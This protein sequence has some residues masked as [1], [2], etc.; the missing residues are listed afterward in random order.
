M[1]N[2]C[3]LCILTIQFPHF[4]IFSSLPTYRLHHLTSFKKKLVEK[5]NHSFDIFEMNRV[6]TLNNSQIGQL[7]I[8][9]IEDIQKLND[10]NGT[11]SCET[12]RG[13]ASS[14]DI[15]IDQCSIQTKP[16][17]KLIRMFENVHIQ[18]S[19]DSSFVD[20]ESLLQRPRKIS[21]KWSNVLDEF[22]EE[23]QFETVIQNDSTD[24]EQMEIE[25]NDSKD[26]IIDLDSESEDETFNSVQKIEEG[27]YYDWESQSQLEVQ[28]ELENIKYE[29]LK[30]REKFIE[31][32]EDGI[33]D[34]VSF[35][36]IE[37]F[38]EICEDGMVDLVSFN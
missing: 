1:I 26:N 12:I 35:T 2:F 18:P 20:D 23:A 34:L 28:L 3:L 38:I 15:V 36:P 30:P 19:A 29:I 11:S 31:I 17:R 5:N 24:V 9:C 37:K 16:K 7:T 14:E 33:V 13:N 4:I 27:F 32:C 25:K 6:N 21:R 10:L 22:L 8:E